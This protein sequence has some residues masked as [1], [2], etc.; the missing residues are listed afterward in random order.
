MSDFPIREL[1][2]DITA[3]LSGSTPLVIG[4]CGSQG[5]GKSTLATA[6]HDAWSE[7]G[8]SVAVISI[9]DLYFT[10]DERKRI[11]ADVHPLLQTRGVPGTHDVALGI[12]LLQRLKAAAPDALTP[13][14]RFDKTRDDRAPAEAW[15]VFKGRPDVIV[16]EGWCVAAR[17]QESAAL[18]EP[19]NALERL[20]DAEGCWRNYVN[21]QLSGVYRDLFGAIDYLVF[22]KA[23]TFDVVFSWRKEQEQKLP[24]GEANTR[25]MTDADLERFIAHYERLTRHMH[26]DLPSQADMVIELDGDRR[27]LNITGKRSGA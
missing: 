9:D 2:E 26:A 13:L 5:S 18:R 15:D 10:R 21:E 3:R 11:A 6:L 27:V 12:D 25:P 4:L 23:P 19:I 14:P 7:R 1:I 20:E 8:L 17:P 22:L 24:H 16:L